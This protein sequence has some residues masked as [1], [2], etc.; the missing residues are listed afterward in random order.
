VSLT[1]AG[2]LLLEDARRILAAVDRARERVQ[3]TSQGA[4]GRVRLG[5]TE[6]I[7]LYTLPAVLDR[8]RREHPQFGLHF[9]IVPEAG[10]LERVAANDLDMALIAGRVLAHELQ[11]RRIGEDALVLVAPGARRMMTTKLRDERWILRE[12]G[13]DTRRTL[14]AWLRRHRLTPV[15]TLT[16]HGPDAVRRAVLAG[17]GVGLVSRVVVADDLRSGRVV[18]V[19][20][21]PAIP[22]RDILL[23]DHPQKHHGAACRAM[24]ELLDAAEPS[25]RQ[26]V[27]RRRA[28]RR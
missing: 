23:V 19:P 25:S 21:T 24:L 11:T 14:D 2:E 28:R 16:L 4:L 17:L 12:E 10:L 20:L 5:A 8:F 3:G 18:E 9:T 1:V 6:T 27:R 13:S 15:H 26:R 22:P 7:G